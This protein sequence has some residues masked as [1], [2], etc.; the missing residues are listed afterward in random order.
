VKE[1]NPITKFEVGAFIHDW[2]NL[3]GYV[4]KEID[5]EFM[6]IMI[7]LHYEPKII[8]ER[9]LLMRLTFLNVL[10][11]KIKGTYKNQL[12]TNIYKL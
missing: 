5:T 10:R 4:G 11:H 6:C 1:R 9:W 8:I 12:P 3:N 2:R 7:A